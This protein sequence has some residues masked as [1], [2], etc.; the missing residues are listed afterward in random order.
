VVLAA[1]TGRELP[2]TWAYDAEGNATTDPAKALPPAGTMAP[3]GGHKGYA[4][5][6]AVELLT[7][8]LAGDYSSGGDGM[9]VAAIDVGSVT[10]PAMFDRAVEAL[11]ASVASSAPRSGFDRPQLPGAGS[12]AR[13]ERALREGVEVLPSVWRQVID[14]VQGLPLKIPEPLA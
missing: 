5:A 6:V 4:L 11:E 2:D 7:A 10:E 8:A 1:S 12:A 13:K 9:F 14:A 3:L